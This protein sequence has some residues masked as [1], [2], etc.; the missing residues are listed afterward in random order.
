MNLRLCTSLREWFG[1]SL[2][3][4]LLSFLVL[5]ALGEVSQAAASG[6]ALSWPEKSRELFEQLIAIP[7]VKG[8]GKVQDVA[9]TLA[10]KFKEGGIPESDILIKPYADTAALIVRWRSPKPLRRPIMVLGHMDVVEAKREDWAEDPFQLRE[11]GGLFYGRGVCDMKGKVVAL[12]TAILRLK[13]EGFVPDRDVIA[14]F[15]GDEETAGEGARLGS[16]DWKSLLDAEYGLNAEG[17]GGLADPSG[18]LLA[19]SIQTEEKTYQNY[20]FVSTNLGGHS[21]KPRPENAIYDLSKALLKVAAHRFP[22]RINE[23]V[24]SS[25][26]LMQRSDQGPRGDAIRAWLK[27]PKDAEAAA[28]LELDFETAGLTQTR[29]VA[30]Q[31]HAGHAPNALPQKAWANVNCRII[32]GETP[33]G[34]LAELQALVKEFGVSVS[35]ERDELI[36]PSLPINSE[37]LQAYQDTVAERHPGVPVILGMMTGATD[38]RYFRSQGVP[39]F[40]A[41][42]EWYFKGKD[43]RA[44]G[45]DENEVVQSFYENL[46]HWKSLIRRLARGRTP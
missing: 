25:L 7:S 28:K 18:K 42:G 37:V 16:T 22:P 10:K 32:P 8:R 21:S 30:T 13:E 9:V 29:C 6:K 19:F 14:F 31:L 41:G 44:H 11:V 40:G 5:T 23:A 46:D 36:S 26:N 27:N 39:I 38:G 33:L 4:G 12:T 45:R 35:T 17:G 15:T 20:E 43:P 2:S 24:R 34:I 3:M 1:G